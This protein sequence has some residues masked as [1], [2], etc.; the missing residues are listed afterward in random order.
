MFARY[1][2]GCRGTTRQRQV[3]GGSE[4]GGVTDE[5]ARPALSGSSRTRNSGLLIRG[6]GVQVPDGAPTG[7][8]LTWPYT[9][10]GCHEAAR[11]A[12]MFA[13]RLL[14]SPDLVVRAGQHAR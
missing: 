13:P 5:T 9:S 1:L 2:S 14:V 11:F 8:V 3:L 6:F 7:N 10:F 12:V 4:I